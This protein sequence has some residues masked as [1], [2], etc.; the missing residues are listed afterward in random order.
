MAFEIAV[1]GGAGHALE[2]T[3]L[4]GGTQATIYIDGRA[5]AASLRPDGDAWTLTF[6]DR[7]EKV[8]IALGADVVHIHAAGRAW[9]L[10]VIDPAE[11]A[12]AGAAAEDLARAPMPGTV[13]AVA[14]APGERVHA[15]QPLMVIESMKMQS[16][17][18]APRDGTIERVFRAVGDT[19]DRGA[20]L[21]SLVA[22]Q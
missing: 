9:T 3:R 15:A 19:F 5:H 7:S 17:I 18:V 11:Q 14:V 4:A 6:E 12:A 8:W 20:D 22:V 2:L 16:E 10:T 21:V 13:V 1:D